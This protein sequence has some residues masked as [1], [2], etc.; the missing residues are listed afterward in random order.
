MSSKLI[1]KCVHS[2]HT[3][4]TL[5]VYLQEQWYALRLKQLN[6]FI[7]NN[8]HT[9][10]GIHYSVWNCLAVINNQAYSVC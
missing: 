7:S 3:N 1:T 8:L 2:L 9:R 5:Y 4:N 6:C 10:L